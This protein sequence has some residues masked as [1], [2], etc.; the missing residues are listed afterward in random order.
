MCPETADPKSELISPEP[1]FVANEQ[2]FITLSMEKF[3]ILDEKPVKIEGKI[4]SFLMGEHPLCNDD[5]CS[6]ALATHSHRMFILKDLNGHDRTGKTL[7]DLVE[8]TGIS[9]FNEIAAAV[10]YRPNSYKENI[11]IL[12]L[13]I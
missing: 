9:N 13:Y 5:P 2:E 10:E 7:K 4:T 1:E 3:G 11:G 8:M 6:L 12:T